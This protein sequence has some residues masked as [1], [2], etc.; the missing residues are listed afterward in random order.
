MRPDNCLSGLTSLGL[1][2]ATCPA[3]SIRV[4]QARATTNRIALSFVRAQVCL[5]DERREAAD[6]SGARWKFG[7][8]WPRRRGM[9]T[10]LV[11]EWSRGFTIGLARPPS[12]IPLLR[13]SP[14]ARPRKSKT[15]RAYFRQMFN[16]HSDWLWGRS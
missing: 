13:P 6:W 5:Q 10:F 2:A 16:E 1:S 15:Q 14:M 8:S 9:T 11:D 7:S 12:P 4:R 3:L